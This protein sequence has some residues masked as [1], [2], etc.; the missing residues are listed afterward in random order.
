MLVLQ[1][2]AAA[3]IERLLNVK[4]KNPATGQVVRRLSKEELRPFLSVS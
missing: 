2:Y 1:T 3:C 4:D